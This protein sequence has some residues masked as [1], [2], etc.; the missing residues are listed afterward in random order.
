LGVEQA[1]DDQIERE[2]YHVVSRGYEYLFNQGQGK[3]NWKLVDHTSLVAM[4]LMIREPK[5]SPWIK[6]VKDWLISQQTEMEPGVAS[7]DECVSDTAM[8]LIA[9]LRMG[10]Q[11]SDPAVAK[12][13]K[14]LQKVFHYNKRFNWE[15]EPWETS[16]S[17]TAIAESGDYETLDE[18]CQGVRW[19]AG[20]Q[21]PNG[22]II[23][24]HYTAYFVNVVRAVCHRQ[25]HKGYCV[26]DEDKL[27]ESAKRASE[28]LLRT[29]T[30]E[31]LWTGEAWSNGQ[32]IWSLASGGLFPIE[33][34]KTLSMV[35]SWFIRNQEKDGGWFDAEDT[36]CAILGLVAI[37]KEYLLH[38]AN[39]H[40][41]QEDVETVISNHLRRLYVTPKLNLKKSFVEVLEDGTTTLNFSPRALK[42]A[43][44]VFAIV[45][46]LTVI[47][48][49]W[50]FIE[51]RFMP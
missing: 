16:W 21:E 31:D 22:A 45:S 8:A 6:T 13:L 29:M 40:G 51:A 47:I 25:T 23:A 43:A 42:T 7:W 4:A 46:G 12:G 1:P 5:N 32:I 33:D 14:F 30:E 19:L 27:H 36:A 9:L 24:P 37:L 18:A 2:I 3:G 10:V 39:G 35:V 38:K 28:Y 49:L 11:P 17:I 50:D 48:A 20:I 15:D 41:I 44:I 34:R 26:M